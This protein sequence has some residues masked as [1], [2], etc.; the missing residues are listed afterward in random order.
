MKKIA[1]VTATRAEYGLLSPIIKELRKYES[2]DLQVNLIVT[3]TH[4]SDLFG[5]TV[6]EIENDNVR[7][8][9]RIPIS[10]STDT[11]LDISKNQADVLIKFTEHFIEKR[12]DAVIIFGDRY[13]ALSIAIAAGNSR[14]PI[15]HI[16]GGDT[17]EGALDEWMRH[18][19]TKMSC[20]HFVTNEDSKSRVIQLGEDPHYVYNYGST[21][22]D[23][24]LHMHDI[25]KKDALFEIGLKECKYAICTYHPVTMDMEGVE[26]QISN[27]IKAIS[28]FPNIRFIVTK[29]N[30]DQG[31]SKINKMLDEA[32]K[33]INNLSVYTS[34]GIQK[35][36]SL[37]K[38]AEL[39]LGNSSSGIV[40]APAF[41][42][43]TVNI[44]DRQRGRLQ[45]GSVIN[46]GDTVTNIVEAVKI[47]L[48]DE[49]RKKCLHVISPY[50]DGQAAEKIAKKAVETVLTGRI[51]LKK[52][53]YDLKG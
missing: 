12:Y 33:K 45:S 37:M 35:Y 19:I 22:I 52:R 6:H 50:G 11:E 16:S 47:A 53:F 13:E 31:G 3:G 48:S 41:R 42:V 28:Y 15:F 25:S 7:I 32:E 9:Y 21:S 40:E 27:F 4:L 43:P 2:T 14:T 34:L 39:V 51:D 46:C 17:T 49:H 36:L 10:V 38:H 1:V 5:A 8:D 29:S 18:S 30:A 44:G 23:N 26:R 24:I 20:L